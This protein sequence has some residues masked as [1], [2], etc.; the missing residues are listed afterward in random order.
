M[1][2]FVLNVV[3]QIPE[4]LKTIFTL[5]FEFDRVLGIQMLYV[6]KLLREFHR[7]CIILAAAV[8]AVELG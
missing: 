2:S 1:R 3:T 6:F 4:M 8:F 5:E 7:A